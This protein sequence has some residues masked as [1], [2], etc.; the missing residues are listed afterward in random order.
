MQNAVRE[1]VSAIEPNFVFDSHFV[2][3]QVIKRHSDAYIHFAAP[4]DTTA[5]MHG[6]I[7]QLIRDTGLVA[8]MDQ[9]SW[10]DTIHGDP[11]S[12]ALWR[13]TA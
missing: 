1:V 5:A 7:A 4:G 10:S 9:E 12:N 3:S 13:R 6:R 8:R 2:I 11:G